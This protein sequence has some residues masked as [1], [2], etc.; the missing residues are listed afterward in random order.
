MSAMDGNSAFSIWYMHS[1][2]REK[3]SILYQDLKN[4]G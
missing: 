2:P 1:D 3:E 4:T